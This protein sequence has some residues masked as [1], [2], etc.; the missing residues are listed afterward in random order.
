MFLPEGISHHS[1]WL[2]GCL[3]VGILGLYRYDS[4]VGVQVLVGVL[5]PYCLVLL[6]NL[7]LAV[8]NNVKVLGLLD[9]EAEICLKS[10]E[11]EPPIEDWQ[12]VFSAGLMCRPQ[13][14]LVLRRDLNEA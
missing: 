12:F 6:Q 9:L 3:K 4:V 13:V 2:H 11:I 10:R 7:T 14:P 1:D 5:E 8:E